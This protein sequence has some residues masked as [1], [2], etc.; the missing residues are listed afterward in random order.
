MPY[1]KVLEMYVMNCVVVLFPQKEEIRKMENNG[2][3]FAA[4]PHTGRGPVLA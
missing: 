4:M 3:V 1:H 2:T